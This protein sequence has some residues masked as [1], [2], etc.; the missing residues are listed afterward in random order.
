[1]PF[2]ESDD[3]REYDPLMW[4]KL[5][6]KNK[7]IKEKAVVR[8]VKIKNKIEKV[9]VV[10]EKKKKPCSK[11]YDKEYYETKGR[12]WYLE[13]REWLLKLRK[14]RYEKEKHNEDL[15]LHKYL[16]NKEF[17]NNNKERICEQ[18]RKAYKEKK[19]KNNLE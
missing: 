2:I 3:I 12:Q 11:Q 4:V 15:K 14:E 16:Y 13:N 8:G 7:I 6:E 5:K 19:E 17:Y 9:V 10:K 18:R 1:M